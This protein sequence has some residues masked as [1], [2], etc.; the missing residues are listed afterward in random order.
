VALDADHKPRTGSKP[1][2]E[3]A[4]HRA[5][6]I[7]M[8]RGQIEELLTRYGKIDLLWFDGKVPNTTGDEII[9]QERIRALQ[10]GIVINPRLHGQGDYK[11]YERQLKTDR[12][13]T[14]WAEFCNT[15][16]SSWPHVAGAPFRAPGFV[17]GQLVSARAWHINYLLGVGPTSDGEFVDEIYANFGTVGAW[18]KKNGRAVRGT[19]PLP[20]SERASVPAT[21]LG[22]TRYLFALPRFTEGGA[23]EKDLLPPVD[24]RLTLDAV[25]RPRAVRLLGGP[26]LK[27]AFADGTVTIELPAAQRTKLVDVVEVDL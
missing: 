10:P 23:Y 26:R 24:E 11:T 8:V 9:T 1:P 21:S 3:V 5:Q 16:T 15:W 18:M 25:T 2:E 6:Y 7:A 13:A 19:Q 20:G 14:G 22:K 4:R 27:H 12:V 17:L